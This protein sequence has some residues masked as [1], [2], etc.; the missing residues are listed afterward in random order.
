MV[1]RPKAR[2]GGASGLGRA[3]GFGGTKRA[4]RDIRLFGA[5]T[6]NFCSNLSKFVQIGPKLSKMNRH[7]FFSEKKYTPLRFDF[8]QNRTD[9]YASSALSLFN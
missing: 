5:L 9:L 7:I 3:S 8:R 1:G 6:A 4:K 2:F